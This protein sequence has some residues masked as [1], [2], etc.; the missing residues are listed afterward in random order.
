[1]SFIFES[2]LI[3]FSKQKRNFS[4]L[5]ESLNKFKNESKTSKTKVF[6]S[7]KHGETEALNGT[8]T[9]LKQEGISIYVDWMDEGMPKFTCGLTAKRI[10]EKIKENDKFI[11]LATEGAINSKWCNWELGLGDAAKYIDNI[12]I[13]PVVKDQQSY[14]GS[15]YLEIYPFIEYEDGLNKRIN[16]NYISKGYYVKYPAINNSHFIIEL[17]EWLRR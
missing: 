10:K 3:E 8:I 11:I 2:K 13:L 5:N 14:N 17:S 9:L 6:L 15:E 12:A 4:S 7:H 16:G 1:M